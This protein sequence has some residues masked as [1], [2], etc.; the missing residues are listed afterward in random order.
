MI[1]NQYTI[2]DKVSG[3]YGMPFAQ[4]NDATAIRYFNHLIS[5]NEMAEPSDYDL[6]F[7][8]TFNQQTGEFLSSG[9]RFVAHGA[10][11]NTNE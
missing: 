10:E 2:F 7:V 3:V 9:L 5:R 8:G 1:V 11:V 6:F 4:T